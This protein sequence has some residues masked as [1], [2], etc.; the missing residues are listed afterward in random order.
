MAHVCPWW[1]AY[2]FDNR[3]RRIFYKPE[4]MFAPYVRAGMT[5]LD[6]GCGLGFNSIAL[7]GMVGDEG[8]VIAVDIQQ[9]MLDVLEKR[10]RRGGVADR[11]RV[12]KCQA[13]LIGVENQVGFAL[14]FWMVHE[15]PD[16]PTFLS[17]VCSL[18]THEAGLLVAEPRLHVSAKA[19]QEMVAAAE[20]V[21]LKLCD[22]PRI[23]FSRAALFVRG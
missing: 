13:D 19:F 15:V 2:S 3:L 7:A 11:I 12:H 1:L 14:A 22:R 16:A 9:K 8:C 17:Q 6:L 20:T 10:A 18:L 4:E 21:G 23:R 5:V